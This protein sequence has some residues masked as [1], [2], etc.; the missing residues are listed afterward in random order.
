MEET[1]TESSFINRLIACDSTFSYQGAK[2]LFDH[3][4]Q[5]GMKKFDPVGLRGTYQEYED[6]EEVQED[7]SFLDVSAED[8]EQVL[9]DQTIVI[10]IPNTSRLIIQN[11]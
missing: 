3:L 1:V 6:I 11:F 2:A 9:N 10:R 7:Y 5:A 8:F 4:E